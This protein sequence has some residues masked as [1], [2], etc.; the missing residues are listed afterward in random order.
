MTPYKLYGRQGSGSFAVQVA[1]EEIGAPYER[2]WIANEATQAVEWRAISP[3]GKVPVLALPDGTLMFE[4]AA[5]LIHLAL[6]HP[7][8]DLAPRPGTSRHAQFLQW[9]VFLSA[10]AY[11]AALRTY[12]SDRYSVQGETHAEAI[13]ERGTADFLAHLT[14]ISQALGPFV[15]ESTYSIADVFLY[16]LGSWFPG[17]KP[18]LYA[19]LPR[20][21]VHAQH[22]LQRPAVIKTETDHGA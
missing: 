10:N 1:L 3:T 11:E 16:M 20:L 2:V 14:L 9:M 8:A 4:S 13:R 18:A 19:Q 21:G 17:G 5:M 12:Y 7:E 15:L 22:M 6:R